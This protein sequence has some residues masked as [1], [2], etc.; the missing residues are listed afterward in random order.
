MPLYLFSAFRAGAYAG[1]FVIDAPP[2][3]EAKILR[4]LNAG[5]VILSS[6]GCT[7]SRIL[8]KASANIYVQ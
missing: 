2:L 7:G 5:C 1:D 8:E 3:I 4:R 6:S